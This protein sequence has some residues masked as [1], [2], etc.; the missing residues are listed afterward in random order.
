MAI[1]YPSSPTVGQRFTYAGITYTWNG[2]AWTYTQTTTP[3]VVGSV[4]VTAPI[5]NTGTPTAPVIGI[6]QSALAIAQSQVSGLVAALAGKANLAGGNNFTDAQVIGTNGTANIGLVVIGTASQSA[7]LQQWR[8][9]SGGTVASV[10][11]G[12]AITAG[13]VI[14]SAGLSLSGTIAP[15][16][17]NGSAGTAGQVL[18]SAG[19]GATPTWTTPSAGGSFTGGTLTSDLVL[20]A[21]TGTV[22][23]IVFRS[24]T[25]TPTASAGMV[26]YD[27]DKFYATTSGTATGRMMLPATAWAYSNAS[28]TQA[29]STTAQSIFQIGART[30]PLEANKTYY[31]KLVL[32]WNIAWTSGGPNTGRLDPTFSNAPQEINYV[33]TTLT[34]SSAFSNRVTATTAANITPA[35][36]T[37]N[38]AGIT[39]IEGF[40]RSNATTGGTVEFKYS[41]SSGGTGGITMLAGCQEQIIKIGSGASSPTV[42]S[43]TWS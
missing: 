42:I 1:P 18:T 23:P 8:N 17:L 3:A 22:R 28:A 14:S 20:V 33:V 15:V 41:V 38:T 35:I 5:T 32:A 34:S 43:G 10:S 21:G 36:S 40:F 30:L 6:N 29:T 16:L 24:N 7:D 39:T 12:G 26:D 19:G 37:N 11:V 2:V 4:L 27:G 13:S 31:F 9:S 25:G